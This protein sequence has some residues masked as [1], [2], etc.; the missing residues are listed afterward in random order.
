VGRQND[1]ALQVPDGRYAR[2]GQILPMKSLF[3]HLEGR[4]TLGTYVINELNHCRFLPSL[5]A[6]PTGLLDLAAFK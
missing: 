2:I 5:I 4:Q 3:W 1:Y 6:I